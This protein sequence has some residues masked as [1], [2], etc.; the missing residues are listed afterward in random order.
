[1]SAV[2]KSCRKS[3]QCKAGS[4]LSQGSWLQ[5]VDHSAKLTFSGSQEGLGCNLCWLYNLVAAVARGVETGYHLSSTSG[6][7][8]ALEVVRWP[9]FPPLG[10]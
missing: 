9:V 1:M 6:T 8:L 4:L 3:P 2:A 10:S 7:T 5:V